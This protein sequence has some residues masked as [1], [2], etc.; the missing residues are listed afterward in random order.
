MIV[1]AMVVV[2]WMVVV[3]AAVLKVMIIKVKS[4]DMILPLIK[5]LVTSV[6]P[7]KSPRAS[8]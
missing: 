7:Q 6:S 1:V 5:T 8:D 2:V 3:V 4:A